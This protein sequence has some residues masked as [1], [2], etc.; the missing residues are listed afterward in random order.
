[1]SNFNLNK[2]FLGGRLTATP[3]L[4]TTPSGITLCDFTVAVNRIGD[5][6]RT[7]DFFRCT[8]WSKK[9]E[10]VSKFFTKGSPICIIG[11]VQIRS[12]T[13][14]GGIKRKEPSIKVDEV[15][16]VDGKNDNASGQTETQPAF[17]PFA[18]AKFEA[19]GADEDM[20][21]N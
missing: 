21:F 20:P 17:D 7:A 16:F 19:I 10:F 5:E 1:M 14:N 9:A 3:E 4:K 18:G 2:I 15:L 6:D 13:D 12:Y 8:A 11:S